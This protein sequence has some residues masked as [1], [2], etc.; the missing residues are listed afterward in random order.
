MSFVDHKDVIEALPPDRA[1]EAFAMPAEDGLRL[2]DDQTRPPASPEAREPNPEDPISP[3]EPR[4]LHRA[5]EEGDLLAE[6]QVL[7]GERRAALE[8]QPQEY[9]DELQCAPIEAPA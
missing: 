6:R 1:A 9:R 5:L 2:G 8:Q 7:G 3:M 4:A